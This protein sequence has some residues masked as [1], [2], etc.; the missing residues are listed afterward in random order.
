MD[1]EDLAKLLSLVANPIRVDIIKFLDNEPRSF[2]DFL[3]EL[4]LEST[5]KLSFHLEKLSSL[6]HKNTSGLYE[7]TPLGE[8]IYFLLLKFENGEIK[9]ESDPQ[10]AISVKSEDM[11][12]KF[13]KDF[14]LLLYITL[15]VGVLFTILLGISTTIF[16]DLDL[17]YSFMYGIV[18]IFP[19]IYLFTYL[20]KIKSQKLSLSIAFHNSFTLLILYIIG[21][22]IAFAALNFGFDHDK[23]PRILTTWIFNEQYDH[24]II[25]QSPIITRNSIIFIWL[26]I[27][28]LV[29]LLMSLISGF[30]E[31]KIPEESMLTLSKIRLFTQP[32]FWLISGFSLGIL[33]ILTENLE[34]DID[35]QYFATPPPVLPTTGRLFPSFAHLFPII[36]S[37]VILI[38][39]FLTVQRP[40][41]FERNRTGR[42]LLTTC[43]LVPVLLITVSVADSLILLSSQEMDEP[44]MIFR[45]FTFLFSKLILGISQFLSL[46]GFSLLLQNSVNTDL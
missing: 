2:S 18:L 20:W 27:Y 28:T 9:L 3:K 34:Y 21:V 12:F 45:I 46:I 10:E 7:L 40:E 44:D 4:S 30:Q 17:L 6:I 37:L 29:F 11:S 15:G 32:H 24:G 43:L 35:P 8:K 16:T 39:I 42:I 23:F 25:F 19:M 1:S 14:L 5:S 26:G 38:L 36:P 31:N 41:N 33:S 13:R 22:A